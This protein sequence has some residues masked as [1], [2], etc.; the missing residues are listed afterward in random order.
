MPNTKTVTPKWGKIHFKLVGLPHEEISQ[1][2][3]ISLDFPIGCPKCRATGFD[4]IKDG[5]ET[6][7]KG[8]PQKYECKVCGTKFVTHT[9]L[10]FREVTQAVFTL[11]FNEVTNTRSSVTEVA[12]RFNMA[13]TTLHE[14][15]ARVRGVLVTK[16]DLVKKILARE[17]P[18]LMTLT[19]S[20][21]AI[22]VDETFL[23]IKGSTYYLIV[24]INSEGTPLCWKLAS[25]R[26]S[27]IITGVIE[28]LIK[29]HGKPGMI[30]TDGNPTYKKVLTSLR[31]EGIHVIHIHKDKRNRIVIRRCRFDNGSQQYTEELIGV[32]HDVFA[33]EGTKPVWCLSSQKSIIKR[34]GKRG[35]PKGSKNRS[36]DVKSLSTFSSQQSNNQP[37]K[38][39]PKRRG[40]K[41]VFNNGRLVEI[42][43]GPKLCLLEIIS[44]SISPANPAASQTDVSDP[45]QVLSLLFPVLHEFKGHYISSNRIENLFSQLDYLFIPRGRRTVTSVMNETST[46]LMLRKTFSLLSSVIHYTANSFSSRI[47]LFNLG[48]LLLPINLTTT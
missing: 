35:R 7:T 23:K 41:N 13:T 19:G 18:H 28:E 45:I 39:P 16:T 17:N 31:Y 3:Y 4:I 29:N 30:I 24:A 37:S 32:N 6:K 40:S 36:K 9:S 27:E 22:F 42:R 46:W 33:T 47:G 26:K 44:P 11:A 2:I 1:G 38:Q 5:H 12:K 20:N 34:G 48:K 14:F 15:V 8:H 25:S 10:F 43:V 21:K